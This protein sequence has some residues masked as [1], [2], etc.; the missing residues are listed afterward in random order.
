MGSIVGKVDD[1]LDVG[2]VGKE[3]DY[4]TKININSIPESKLQHEFKHANDFGIDGN[5][6][7]N[8]L[9][10]MRKTELK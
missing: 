9:I 6:M 7:K 4:A 10:S 3:I 8:K 2:K 1:A 5:L